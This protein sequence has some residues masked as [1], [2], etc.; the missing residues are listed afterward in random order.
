MSNNS[1]EQFLI[2]MSE[3]STLY[4]EYCNDPV[5]TMKKAGLS[6]REIEVLSSDDKKAINEVIGE[7]TN[8]IT[9][10]KMYSEGLSL[11]G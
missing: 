6:A 4:Q 5:G 1:L 9:I 10:I 7:K 11:R 3:D 2:N 8:C